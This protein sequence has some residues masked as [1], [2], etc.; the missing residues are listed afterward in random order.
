MF[1]S[2][3]LAG[4]ALI[5]GAVMVAGAAQAQTPPAAS[6]SE[7]AKPASW[8]DTFSIGGHVDGGITFNSRGPSDGINFG[9]LFGD[10][11]NTALLNQAMLTVQR[12]IDPKLNAF[13]FGFKL[14]GMYGTDARYTHSLGIWDEAIND[15]GQ[16]DIVEAN[17]LFHL[18]IRTGSSVDFKLGIFPSPMSAEVISA[19]DNPLY[20]HSYIFQF[21]VP[22]KNTGVL[23]TVHVNDTLDLYL[24]LDTGANTSIG[25]CSI[26]TGDNNAAVSFQ[27]G[28]GL[29]GLAGGGLSVVAL[30]HMGPENANQP[31]VAA[32]CNCD[33]NR[34]FRYYMDVVFN[35]AL[36]DSWTLI[37]DLNWV[38]DDGFAADGYGVAGYALYKINDIFKVVGRAEVWRDNNGFFVAAFPGNLD[39]AKIQHGDPSGIALGGG[40]TTYA[41]FTLGLNITPPLPTNPVVKS[42][43]FRPEVRFDT[44]LNGTTPFAAGTAPNQFTFAGDVIFKF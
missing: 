31:G 35:W 44:S 43:I 2:I 22:F 14:Q 10:R 3:A 32:L 7:P 16:I 11:A 13:D 1:R 15:I 20:S 9:Q 28:F 34:A 25:C 8:W 21:G 26:Y 40:N 37:A 23:A 41:G 6:P 33:P 18:P 5:A 4:A 36:N 38:R 27:A 29:N 39:Y 19:P 42:L 12:P 17:L 30:T 24:G